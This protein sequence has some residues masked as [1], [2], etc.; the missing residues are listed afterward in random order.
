MGLE[1]IM[2]NEINQIKKISWFH[3]F[4]EAKEQLN[5]CNKTETNHR[6]REIGKGHMAC[7]DGMHTAEYNILYFRRKK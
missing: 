5:K 6:H 1:G 7:N 3:L 2:L 4:M